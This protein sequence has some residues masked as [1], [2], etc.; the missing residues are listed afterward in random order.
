M[1]AMSLLAH[2]LNTNRICRSTAINNWGAFFL[3]L[4][5]FLLVT[6]CTS[7][8]P[9]IKIGLIAPFEGLYRQSGYTALDA[10]RQAMA[11]CTP[12]GMDVLPLALD[13]SGDP[14]RAQRAAQKLLIDPSVGAIV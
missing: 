11:E 4:L 7:I 2:W 13:D 6:G 5:A 1:A 10:M 9:I 8:R 3:N 14:A 12:P